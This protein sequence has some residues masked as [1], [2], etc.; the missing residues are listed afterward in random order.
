MSFENPT[1]LRLGMTANFGGKQYRLVGR[2]VLG[3]N[4]EGETYYWNEFNL[5]TDAGEE[6][7]LVFDET[8]RS[9]QWR[10]FT[11]FDPEYP[12]T[13]EDAAGKRVGDRLNLT[14]HDVR[15]TFRGSSCVYHMEGKGPEGE[16]V[17]TAAEYFNAEAG[18]IMQVVSWTGEDVEYYD[19]AS[20]SPG[21]V[22]SAFKLPQ[23]L[24]GTGG[25]IFSSFSGSD[26]SSG[27]YLSATKF[28]IS[29]MVLVFALLVF[30]RFSCSRSNEAGPVAKLPAPRRPLEVGAAGTLFDR[31]LRVTG[32]AVVDIAEVGSNWERHE[33]E[34]TDDAGATALLVCGDKAEGADWVYFEPLVPM[35][36]LTAEEIAA[37]KVGDPVEIDGF[38]GKVNG[39]FLATFEQVDGDGVSG[40]KTGTV[41]YSLGGISEYRTLLARWNGS[42]I[43]FFRGRTLPAKKG[44]SCF[45]NGK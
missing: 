3:E 42:G 17:G 2:S 18:S 5:E 30:G 35:I 32:H 4:E 29:A 26:S 41:C 11:L 16:G 7:T 1:R 19:G 10:L 27:N 38:S 37:K 45:A 31:K 20:L 36:S 8:E 28:V 15:V 25:R 22:A 39:I 23:D 13:A 21:L 40:L 44:L 12:M 34:L 43:H 9:S 6:A 33:Y 24:G 14:G